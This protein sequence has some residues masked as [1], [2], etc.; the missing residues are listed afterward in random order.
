VG[1]QKLQKP[2]RPREHG[3]LKPCRF[4]LLGWRDPF[5]WSEVSDA[6]KPWNIIF[7][8][9]LCVSWNAVVQWQAIVQ[10]IRKV[11]GS[12]HDPEARHPVSLSCQMLG[13]HLKADRGRLLP[14]P[15]PHTIYVII[16]TFDAILHYYEFLK[17]NLFSY[18]K[19]GRM[20][21]PMLARHWPIY[22]SGIVKYGF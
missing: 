3:E 20:G 12:I 4:W 10:H 9:P 17:L 16:V 15:S 2:V 5:I 7:K 6:F 18:R 21:Q 1:P 8:L 19:F 22:K 13:Q 11:P 14:H